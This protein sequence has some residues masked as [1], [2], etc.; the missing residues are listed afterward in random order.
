MV[1]DCYKEIYK[2]RNLLDVVGIPYVFE[3]DFL[4]GA[5]LA[6]PNKEEDEFVCSVVKHDWSYGRHD[7]KLE[8]YGLLTEE[9]GS[10]SDVAGGLTAEDVFGRI[11]KHY[12]EEY[13]QKEADSYFNIRLNENKQ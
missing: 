11:S 3:N 7:D 9:E 10:Y 13:K 6:Y 2:L 8:L 4:N 5:A 1:R 12:R